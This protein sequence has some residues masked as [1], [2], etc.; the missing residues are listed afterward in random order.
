MTG[1]TFWFPREAGP[2]PL[3]VGSDMRTL[4]ARSCLLTRALVAALLL[5]GSL[6]QA[7]APAA[8]PVTEGRDIPGFDAA[9]TSMSWNEPELQR[10]DMRCIKGKRWRSVEVLDRQ[11]R[12][13]SPDVQACR[14]LGR[15]YEGG[16]DT[17]VDSKRAIEA[18]ERA[19]MLGDTWGACA[20]LGDLYA[21]GVVVERDFIRAAEYWQVACGAESDARSWPSCE[22]LAVSSFQ[23][24]GVPRDFERG[25][26]SLARVC[27]SFGTPRACHGLTRLFASEE[28]AGPALSSVI[29]L[30]AP[31]RCRQAN[32]DPAC[33]R[34]AEL[35]AELEEWK[36][37]GVVRPDFLA[38]S[39]A[40]DCEA[41]EPEACAFYVE[42]LQKRTNPAVSRLCQVSPSVVGG[43]VQCPFGLRVT[44]ALARGCSGRASDRSPTAC[45]L[46]AR[47][48]RASDDVEERN[49]A[50]DFERW[51]CRLG[52]AEGCEMLNEPM[53][54]SSTR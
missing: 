40:R 2:A 41:G 37:S 50:R 7:T 30:H 52:S 1:R 43:E 51:A 45:L 23:G 28:L 15:R 32:R 47:E 4:L 53:R 21:E 48:A 44:D 31:D 24:R 42:L 35:M 17:E 34:N 19:C 36:R 26:R 8:A 12:A 9:L 33:E 3:E 13:E 49:R 39:A 11:C 22:R 29:A 10:F 6:A 27:F 46:R 14:D 5:A 54:P 16:C 18:Y 38:R 25:V 20:H